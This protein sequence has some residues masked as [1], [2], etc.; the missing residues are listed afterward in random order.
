M[1][2]NIKGLSRKLSK[3]KGDFRKLILGF[4]N[5]NFGQMKFISGNREKVL[6]NREKFLKDLG[7]AGKGILV[8]ANQVHSNRI[9]VFGKQ[10]LLSGANRF[11]REIEI[12]STDG[13]LTELEQV[14]LAITV[15]DCVPIFVWS[16]DLSIIGAVHAGWQGTLAKIAS[17]TIRKII[18]HYHIDPS[19]LIAWIGPS[20]GPTDFEVKDDVFLSFKK[21]YS[22]NKYFQEDNYKK[23]IDLWQINKDQLIEAGMKSSK[24]IIQQESTYSNQSYY[25]YR[26]G[27]EG[28][29]MGLIGIDNN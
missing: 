4:S 5:K 18:N 15:A 19:N 2:T 13:L 28:R 29:M 27:D 20:I 21:K 1:K 16:E 3:Q 14:W 24:I 17:K 8:R 7:I 12:K 11:T 26:R 10:D 22:D 9:I 6:V 23:Y 25:S